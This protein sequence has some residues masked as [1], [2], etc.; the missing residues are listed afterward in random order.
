M[1][2]T[3][4]EGPKNVIFSYLLGEPEGTK[5]AVGAKQENITPTETGQKVEQQESE[6]TEAGE[7][8]EMELPKV[9]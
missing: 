5:E 9:D 2:Q 6:V 8:S 4:V 1:G 7:E 3:E